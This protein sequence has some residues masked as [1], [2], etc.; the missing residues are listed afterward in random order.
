MSKRFLSGF[1]TYHKL[2]LNILPFLLSYNLLYAFSDL[3]Y[4]LSIQTIVSLSTIEPQ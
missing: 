3:T 2:E 1:F 4:I